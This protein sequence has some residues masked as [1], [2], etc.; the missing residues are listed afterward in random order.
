LGWPGGP[1]PLRDNI[2]FID[3]NTKNMHKIA[4]QQKPYRGIKTISLIKIQTKRIESLIDKNHKKVND[5]LLLFF[6]TKIFF[7]SNN[8]MIPYSLF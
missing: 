1:E 6:I 2:I 3:E 4:Y 7:Y 5:I 8:I